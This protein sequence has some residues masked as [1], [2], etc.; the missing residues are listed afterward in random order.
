M[1]LVI[2][3][4][5]YQQH[6]EVLDVSGIVKHRLVDHQSIPQTCYCPLTPASS[7]LGRLRRRPNPSHRGRDLPL[8]FP[9]QPPEDSFGLSPEADGGGGGLLLSRIL[10]VVR[11]P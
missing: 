11:G 2:T 4:C 6:Q 3:V 8:P 1:L 10:G 5:H 9:S 7:L